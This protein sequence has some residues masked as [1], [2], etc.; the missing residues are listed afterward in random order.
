M[1]QRRKRRKYFNWEEEIAK[2]NTN[3]FYNSTDFDIYR[4]KVLERDK[5]KCQFFLGKW[6][7]GKHKPDKIKVVDANTVH[8]I[9]PI[10]E[11][12]D[13]ALELSN[14]ISLS[15]EAHEIIEDR[16]NFK[17]RFKKKKRI[18]KEMW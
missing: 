18:S 14:G 4:E 8:H 6:D 10:K 9:V 16:I 3:K 1:K 15:R 2:G 11:R 13:L 12:P 7:D 5:H 17:S